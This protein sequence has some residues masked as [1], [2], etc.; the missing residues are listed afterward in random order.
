MKKNRKIMGGFVAC[1]H[2][3]LMSLPLL[4]G[5]YNVGRHCLQKNL[6]YTSQVTYDNEGNFIET[7][8]EYT[9]AEKVSIGFKDTLVDFNYVDSNHDY[10]TQT[11]SNAITD[12]LGMPFLMNNDY[13][14]VFGIQNSGTLGDSSYIYLYINFYLNWLINM[15]VLVFVPEILIIF[16]DI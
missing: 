5:L 6:S 12:S 13:L 14:G 8:R 3:A 2:C 15:S 9:L 10:S 11:W 1:L 7:S 4:V 16:I